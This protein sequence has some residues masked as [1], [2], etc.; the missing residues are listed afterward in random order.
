MNDFCLTMNGRNSDSIF[1]IHKT[2]WNTQSKLN[3][4]LNFIADNREQNQHDSPFKEKSLSNLFL[5][6]HSFNVTRFPSDPTHWSWLQ[7][8]FLNHTASLLPTR[9]DTT[10]RRDHAVNVT[11]STFR[12][13][14]I[15]KRKTTAL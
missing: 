8:Q 9:S 13:K 15:M 12:F 4:T 2:D 5:N 14:S 6:N 7:L 11:L 10:P 3:G 1:L